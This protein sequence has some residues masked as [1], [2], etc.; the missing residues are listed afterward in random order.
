MTAKPKSRRRAVA[1]RS[2]KAGL[3]PGTLVYTGEQQIEPVRITG[4]DYDDQHVQEKQVASTEECFPFRETPTVTWINVDGL[5]DV[6]VIEKLGKAFDLHPLLLEDILSTAQRP[7]FEDYEKHL[8]VVL[9]ML[10]FGDDLPTIETEQ[11]SLI[12]G[13]NFVLSFQERVGDVFDIV[14][15]RI[16]N[17][18]GRVRRFGADYLAY[19]LLDAIVDSYFAVLEKV[20]EKIED[21]EEELVSDP[22]QATLRRIHGLKREMINLRRSIWP[23]REL[24]NGLHRSESTLITKST[25]IYLRDVYDHT[26]HLIDTI[27]S[28]RDMISGMLDIYLSSVSNRMN[29]VMKVLTIIATLFI[30]LTFIAGVYG[31]NFE[32]MPE[33][34]WRY[35]Y[36]AIWAVMIVVASIMLVYFRRK[37]WL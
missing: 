32:H 25:S 34:R 24:V 6:S 1:K 19:S 10:H 9:R 36:A 31:M 15:D 5:H 30:P 37:R 4:I 18:K 7:K 3:P 21:L 12:L 2:K 17:G 27:E 29:A 13:P 33:L 14:R 35:G 16:R 23:L 20:G 26:I 28:Y 11:V 22:N 8:F